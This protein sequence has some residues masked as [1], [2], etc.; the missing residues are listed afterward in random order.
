LPQA[1]IKLEVAALIRRQ[2]IISSVSNPVLM[3]QDL[4]NPGFRESAAKRYAFL[5]SLPKNP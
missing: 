1:Q 5:V 3:N 4:Q 2:D